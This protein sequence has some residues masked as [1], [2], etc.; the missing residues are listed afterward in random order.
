MRARTVVACLAVFVLAVSS[1]LAADPAAVAS[2]SGAT[3]SDG[4]KVVAYY[5]HGAQRCKTCLHIE[6]TAEKVMRERFGEELKAGRLTW[7][8]ANIDRAENEH[9]VKDFQ[10]VSSSVVLVE[11]DGEKPVRYKVLDR[12]WQLARDDFEFEAYVGRE[13]AAFLKNARG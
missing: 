12:V 1:L 5:F 6:S 11:L 13:T 8:T 2:S 7:R 9:F 3:A 4:H 10:L